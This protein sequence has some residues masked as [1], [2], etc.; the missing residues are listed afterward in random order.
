MSIAR[1]YIAAVIL[2]FSI[3]LWGCDDNGLPEQNNGPISL[4]FNFTKDSSYQ[5]ILDSKMTLEPVVNGKTLTI[6][7]QMKLLSNY[8][9]TTSSGDNKNVAVTYN[10]ITMSSSNGITTNEYDSEDT[11]DQNPMFASVGAMMKRTFNISVSKSGIT[12][13]QNLFDEEQLNDSSAANYGDS[14]LR[15]AMLQFLTMYPAE[16]IKPG[17]T[18]KKEFH[19]SNGFIHM[20]LENTYTLKSIDGNIAHLELQGKITPEDTTQAMIF[21]GIQSGGLDVDIKT[22]LITIGLITQHLSG[23]ISSGGKTSEVSATSEINLI[24]NKL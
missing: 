6:T 3:A 21:S 7:Q 8:I 17:D 10:R 19:T 13:V 2:M 23:K 22:G 18:W 20:K 9:V 14:S 1:Y 12:G 16:A 4:Q 15:K 24:G 11:V 5:Y